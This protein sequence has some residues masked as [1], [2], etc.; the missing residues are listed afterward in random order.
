MEMVTEVPLMGELFHK[1]GQ[2]GEWEDLQLDLHLPHLHALQE[3]DEVKLSPGFRFV[4]PRSV[5]GST[6]NILVNAN[7]SYNSF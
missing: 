4:S 5:P 2:E 3:A 6:I 7:A 1:L